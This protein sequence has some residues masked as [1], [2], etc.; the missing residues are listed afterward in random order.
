MQA[1]TKSINNRDPSRRDWQPRGATDQLRQERRKK[2]Q[3][4]TRPD[5][6]HDHRVRQQSQQNHKHTSQHACTPSHTHTHGN[7][8][9][10]VIRCSNHHL[11]WAALFSLSF[12]YLAL[13]ITQSRQGP[14]RAVVIINCGF[15]FGASKEHQGNSVFLHKSAGMLPTDTFQI[16]N[17]RAWKILTDRTSYELSYPSFFH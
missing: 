2:R 7:L 14:R 17:I 10:W 15:F 13:L 12:V 6:N 16:F 9:T 8:S 5:S 1:G 11:K 3:R 4:S